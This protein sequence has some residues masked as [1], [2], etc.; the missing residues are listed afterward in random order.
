[1]FHPLRT[2]KGIRLSLQEIFPTS[3][4]LSPNEQAQCC[5]TPGHCLNG[6]DQSSHFSTYQAACWLVSTTHSPYIIELSTFNLLRMEK[7]VP[8]FLEL[9]VKGEC[10]SSEQGLKELS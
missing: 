10:I 1:M 2:P 3:T 4:R 8:K 6:L 9:C 5:R 7:Q